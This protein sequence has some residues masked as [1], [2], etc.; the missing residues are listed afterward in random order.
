[1]C[2]NELHEVSTA[3]NKSLVSQQKELKRTYQQRRD[4][5]IAAYNNLGYNLNEAI[6]KVNIHHISRKFHITHN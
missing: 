1:M 3:L 5:R 6:V 4:E 2:S